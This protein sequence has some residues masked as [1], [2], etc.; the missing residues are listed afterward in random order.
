MIDENHYVYVKRF[1]DKFVV[2]SLYVNDILLTNNN[3][4]YI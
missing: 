1:K 4:E 3:K 2:L